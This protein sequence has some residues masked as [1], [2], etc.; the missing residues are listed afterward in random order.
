MSN[1]GTK[2][3]PSAH[4]RSKTHARAQTPS[5]G[6]SSVSK[7]NNKRERIAAQGK[8]LNLELGYDYQ[9]PE[10]RVEQSSRNEQE[11]QP[12]LSSPQELK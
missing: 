2:T 11:M 9:E 5:T 3:L 10:I 7:E 12:N 1:T 4:T 8:L 6:G